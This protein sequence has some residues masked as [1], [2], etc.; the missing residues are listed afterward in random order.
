M[1]FGRRLQLLKLSV[2]MEK[3]LGQWLSIR[4]QLTIWAGMVGLKNSTFAGFGMSE[5]GL[6]S[7]KTGLIWLKETLD[8]ETREK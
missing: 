8:K 5:K 2:G 7:K 3:Y 1:A 4:V 6:N